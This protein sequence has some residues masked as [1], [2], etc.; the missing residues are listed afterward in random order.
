MQIINFINPASTREN[1]R[2]HSLLVECAVCG[3]NYQQT[4]EMLRETGFYV[5]E[6][7]YRIF[8]Q[9]L[10]IQTDLDIGLRQAEWKPAAEAQDASVEELL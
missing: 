8:Q 10:D 7:Q 4:D 2:A 5:P 3:F 9:L 6:D 1:S